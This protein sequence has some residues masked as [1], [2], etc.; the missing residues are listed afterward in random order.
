MHFDLQCLPPKFPSRGVCLG[1]VRLG[2]RTLKRA[3]TRICCLI[4]STEEAAATR[5]VKAKTKTGIEFGLKLLR[6]G[7]IVEPG[8]DDGFNVTTFC[9]N[10]ITSRW[11]QRSELES[12]GIQAIV[13]ELG[14]VWP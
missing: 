4:G 3:E 5:E 7:Y 14:A 11:V 13:T 6:D 2:N 8:S 1:G 12:R 10:A 9:R